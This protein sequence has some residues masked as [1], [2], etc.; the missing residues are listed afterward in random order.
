VRMRAHQ[1]SAELDRK[2]DG[3]YEGDG[4]KL[5][6]QGSDGVSLLHD[7]KTQGKNCKATA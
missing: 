3:V 2:A 5:V 1:G 4:Y 6:T 7:G